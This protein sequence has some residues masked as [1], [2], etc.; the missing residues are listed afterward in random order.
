M[1]QKKPEVDEHKAHT[2]TLY[3]HLVEEKNLLPVARHYACTDI[4]LLDFKCS[5]QI[6]CRFAR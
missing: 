1:A 6:L 5:I 4:L 2:S 3:V